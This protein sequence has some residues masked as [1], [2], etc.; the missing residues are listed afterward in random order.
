MRISPIK[1]SPHTRGCSSAD[2]K[3]L[4]V[5]GVFPAYAGM[6]RRRHSRPS[7]PTR[8]PRIRG[9]VPN[10]P[11]VIEATLRFSPHTRGCSAGWGVYNKEV[12]VFPAYAGMFRCT[13]KG[14][15]SL[16]RFPRIR[17]D[18]PRKQPKQGR[19]REFSPHTR[20]CSAGSSGAGN[21]CFV[22]PAYAGMFRG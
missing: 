1:F 3:G 12:S 2:R 18:V 20:G 13:L 19:K 7:D 21:C 11:A 16:K 14:A 9:D 22:F 5:H 6:F 17:G 10:H 8:F 15:G 4:P